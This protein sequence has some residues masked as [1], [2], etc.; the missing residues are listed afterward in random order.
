MIKTRSGI[1]LKNSIYARPKSAR[2]SDFEIRSKATNKPVVKAKNI[3]TIDIYNVR[4]TP[5][6]IHVQ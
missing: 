5:L 1:A 2:G 3:A 4:P 6:A